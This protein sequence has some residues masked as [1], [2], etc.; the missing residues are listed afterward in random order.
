MSCASVSLCNE[1]EGV[2]RAGGC[3]EMPLGEMKIDRR[4][5]KVAM[6]EQ[7]LDGA[8]VG[9]GFEQVCG[10]AMSKRMRMDMLVRKAGAFSGLLTGGPENLGGDRITCRMPSVAGE[11]PSVGL[12]LSPRQ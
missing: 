12:R 6:S 4:F 8:Q 9:A 1:R 11:Q 2:E 7:H 10:E 5:L 3:A